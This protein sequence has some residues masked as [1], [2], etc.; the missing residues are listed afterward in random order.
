[1]L[2]FTRQER[3]VLATLVSV[4][5]IGTLLRHFFERRPEA[6]RK[7]HILQG[8][9]LHA[10]VDINKAGYEELVK[11]PH[12]GPATAKRILEYRKNRGPF[13]TIEELLLVKG[14]GSVKL[15]EI[16][17]YLTISGGKRN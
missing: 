11:L 8:G 9:Q 4:F 10:T 16:R 2:P 1:M 3:A 17:K 15:E 6:A 14:I 13:R 12:I 5:V 7:V